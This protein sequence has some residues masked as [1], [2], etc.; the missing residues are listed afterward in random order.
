MSLESIFGTDKISII[1]IIII[2]IKILLLLRTKV[3][4]HKNNK[5]IYK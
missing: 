2:N 5:N 4:L 1:Q 3:E